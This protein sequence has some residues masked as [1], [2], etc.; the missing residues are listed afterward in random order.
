MMRVKNGVKVDVLVIDDLRLYFYLRFIL[1]LISITM[2]QPQAE[3]L[4]LDHI[5]CK[6]VNRL[7]LRTMIVQ[8]INA[9]QL[10]VTIVMNLFLTIRVTIV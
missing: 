5:C 1:E 6:V 10:T 3:A 2:F 9:H 8:F 7:T 4:F